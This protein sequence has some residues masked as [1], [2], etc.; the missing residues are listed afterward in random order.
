MAIKKKKVQ[1]ARAGVRDYAIAAAKKSN[2]NVI[3]E[4][5]EAINTAKDVSQVLGGLK[6]SHQSNLFFKHR[7]ESLD[8]LKASGF[9]R[10]EAESYI[11]PFDISQAQVGERDKKYGGI[12]GRRFGADYSYEFG[13]LHQMVRKFLN[14]KATGLGDLF[15]SINERLKTELTVD[16]YKG[17][18]K[19]AIIEAMKQY[20]EAKVLNKAIGTALKD[21]GITPPGNVA[22]NIEIFNA[23][24]ANTGIAGKPGSNTTVLSGNSVGESA[25]NAALDFIADLAQKKK[26]GEALPEWAEKLAGAAIGVENK[27]KESAKQQ[28][29][30]KIG[31][32]IVN[33]PA[34]AGLGLLALMFI[35]AKLIK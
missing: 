4:A 28:A 1:R 27:V 32:W 16:P 35:G 24:N 15:Y 34:Q 33:N 6:N 10:T 20:D 23:T 29:G 9:S 31:N 18:T 26:N 25:A 7:D 13:Q 12:K 2:F 3:G 19:Q 30:N 17:N 14:D 8:Q 21:Q 5:K 11:T 22:G